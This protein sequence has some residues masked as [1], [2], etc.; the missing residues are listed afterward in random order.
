MDAP[1]PSPEDDL[2]DLTFTHIP[3]VTVTSD[4]EFIAAVDVGLADI[5]AGRTVDL[6]TVEAEL[7]RI[8]HAVP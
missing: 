5:D 4:D 7:Q 8:I 6:A 1:K 2:S 3:G